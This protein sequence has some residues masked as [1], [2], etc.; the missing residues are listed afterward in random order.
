MAFVTAS[1]T[2]LDACAWL[3]RANGASWIGV[4]RRAPPG[5]RMPLDIGVRLGTRVN[6]TGVWRGP[7]GSLWVVGDD[8]QVRR[9]TNPW[10]PEGEQWANQELDAPLTG[11]RGVDPRCVL[12]RG[13]RASDGAHV[14]RLFNGARWNPVASPEFALSAMDLSA[15]DRI[16]V[17]GDGVARWD[18]TGWEVLGI[19]RENPVVALHAPSDD[20]VLVA[21]ADGTF[22]RVTPAG[23][24][25]LGRVP[26]ACAIAVW[27]ERIWIGAG[28]GG[29]W[30]A[31]G[32]E[33]VCV[34][35]D[36]ACVALEPHAES[37]LIA[38]QELI[39]STVDGVG[40]P[41]G[42]RGHLDGLRL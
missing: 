23:L 33:L 22:A 20:R 13:I 31:G 42:C 18:G 16:W 28:T 37:L 10:G 15:A 32:G 11:I 38:C 17:G 36:R 7:D 5:A 34:R 24:E 26:G 12:V 6:L 4:V 25:P 35:A 1:G 29:L 41:G 19:D 2:G 14:L 8:G 21:L 27:R 9:N 39:A 40:F 3:G 30:R